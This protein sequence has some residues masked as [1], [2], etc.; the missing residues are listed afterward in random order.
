MPVECSF[1]RLWPMPQPLENPRAGHRHREAM[2][3]RNRGPTF[4]G[5][6][7]SAS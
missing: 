5:S 2:E 6:F 7:K 3:T 1:G 4:F